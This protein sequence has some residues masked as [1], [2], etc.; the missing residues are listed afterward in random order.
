MLDLLIITKRNNHGKYFSKLAAHSR[1]SIK[2]HFIS[3]FS[4]FTPLTIKGWGN[5]NKREISKRQLK[6]KQKAY[7]K[8]FSF[9][10][11]QFTYQY[12]LELSISLESAQY[13]YLL[14]RHKPK[15][16]AVWNG[17]KAP[18]H[19]A[20]EVAKAHGIPVVYF[21]N[22]LLP[23]TTTIDFKGVNAKNSLPRHAQFYREFATHARTS[24]QMS[25]YQRPM[26]KKRKE[27]PDTVLPEKFIFIPL[28]VPNDSQIVVNSPWIQ[29]MEQL[30]TVVLQAWQES[31]MR[32]YHLVFKAHPS[33][34]NDFKHLNTS[35]SRVLFANSNATQ[36]LIE[37][38]TAVVTIN[39]TVGIESLLLQTPVVTLGDACY[40]I[41]D[42]VLHANSSDELDEI[43]QLL[44][45]WQPDETIRQG[46][47]SYLKHIYCIPERWSVAQQMHFNA[48]DKRLCGEDEYSRYIDSYNEQ[49]A[50]VLSLNLKK[51]V[52]F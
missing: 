17:D 6:R 11:I 41:K 48:L 45:T 21:E 37:K 51:S 32:H 20:V 1:L 40:N 23:N 38:A 35:N 22:G 28:Q 24:K 15:R 14:N 42:L 47:V 13:S 46:F 4:L 33:W 10:F 29:S 43:F 16:I 27:E 7:P 36:E 8:L 18:Y 25:L 19:T 49:H 2:L 3:F 52:N 9:K 30:F 34:P 12:L 31:P 26:H 39:S 5:V 50:N 44:P